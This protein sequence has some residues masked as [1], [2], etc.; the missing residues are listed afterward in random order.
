MGI[1]FIIRGMCGIVC[2]FGALCFYELAVALRK[3]GNRYIFTKETWGDLAGSCTIWAHTLIISATG[4]AIISVTISEHV[5][6]MLSDV[7]RE[8]DQWLVRIMTA[9]CCA[10]SVVINC[11]STSFNAKVQTVFGAVQV[12]DMGVSFGSVYGRCLPEKH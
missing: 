6:G 7:L 2:L 10:I 5:I 1:S 8:E 12:L 3:T 9:S 4:V 11:M